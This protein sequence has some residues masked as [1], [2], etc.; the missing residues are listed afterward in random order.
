MKASS[1]RLGNPTEMLCPCIDCRN[2]CH[3]PVYTVED[4]LVIRGMDQRYKRNTCWSLHGDVKTDKQSD[5]SS[6]DFEAYDLIR[7]AFFD[8]ED[9]TKLQKEDQEDGG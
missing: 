1:V 2:L 7:T 8:G 4:H 9:N 5:G 3:Q 6:Y